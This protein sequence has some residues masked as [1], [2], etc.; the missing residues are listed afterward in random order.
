[1][2]EPSGLKGLLPKFKADVLLVFA[3]NKNT[4]A[5]CAK[6]IAEAIHGWAVKGL[7][8]VQHTGVPPKGL[9]GGQ[10]VVGYVTTAPG[11]VSGDGLGGIDMD[12]PGI[13]LSAAKP[14]LYADFLTN[15]GNN[16]NTPD[17]IADEFT[18]AVYDFL[19]SAQVK[20]TLTGT[21]PPG[22]A[23]VTGPTGVGPGTYTGSGV[24]GIDKSAPGLGLL[25]AKAVLVADLTVAYGNTANT[26]ATLSQSL[27]EAVFK[28]LS[29]AKIETKDKGT[30]GG[31]PAVLSESGAG[32][33]SAPGSPIISGTAISGTIA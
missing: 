14:K 21:V 26:P 15:F 33:T 32:A 31:G 17:Q 2:P 16:K 12:A 4:P 13:G 8:K 27:S 7:P 11:V 22:V 9:A 24:G 20:T 25:A 3:N 28:F 5:D 29:A 23:V 30:A 10:A 1:M 19:V 6:G 18:Q